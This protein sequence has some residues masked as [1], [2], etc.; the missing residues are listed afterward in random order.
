MKI[1]FRIMQLVKSALLTGVLLS[2]SAFADHVLNQEMSSVNFLSTKNVN[3]TESHTFDTFVGA[4]DDS[5]K[6][7]LDV[8][9]TSVNTLIPIRN[10][11]MQNMLFNVTD[12]T[13]ASFSAQ[14]DDSLLALTD[15]KSRAATVTGDLTISGVSKPITFD[16]VVTALADGKLSA[17]TTKPTL[18]NASDY[19]LDA[20]IE[21]LRE[22]AMLENIS[23]SV[24]FSFYVVFDNT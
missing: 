1:P 14:L 7:T 21:M 2:S 9:L 12:Y 10:E 13:K 19:N 17:V 8:D 15:G 3:V 23:K 22:V 24:P 4:I 16:I 5:G 6:L 11:R 18:I 20:G